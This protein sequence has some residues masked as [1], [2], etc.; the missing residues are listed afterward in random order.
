MKN[1]MKFFVAVAVVMGAFACTTDTTEDLGIVPVGKTTVNVSLEASRT[2]LGDKDAEGKYPLFWSAG[3]AIAINGVASQPLAASFDGLASAS[4]I[5][6]NVYHR[7][8][9]TR[10]RES[11]S[12]YPFHKAP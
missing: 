6:W 2:Q 7:I 11:F 10:K 9:P 3:D 12:F 8:C 4:E 5:F 1:L